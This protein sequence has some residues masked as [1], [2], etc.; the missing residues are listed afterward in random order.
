MQSVEDI[1]KRNR[2]V[3]IDKA[4]ETSKTRKLIIAVITYSTA[5]IFL[6][7]IE[8]D[9]PFTSALVPTGGYLLS[10]LS[11][12]VVKMWWVKKYIDRSVNQ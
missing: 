9:V 7:I 10:T 6:L 3:E 2:R 11:L 1:L 5:S 8:N 12:P 4:W